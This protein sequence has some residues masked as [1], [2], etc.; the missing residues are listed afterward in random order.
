MGKPKKIK[1]WNEII[2]EIE[3]VNKKARQEKSSP[4]GTQSISLN[5]DQLL[6]VLKYTG[7]V[8]KNTEVVNKYLTNKKFVVVYK[9]KV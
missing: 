4:K 7:V 3:E 6:E 5:S 1:N 8:P 2:Q 9:H